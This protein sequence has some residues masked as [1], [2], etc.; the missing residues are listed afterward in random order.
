MVWV[1]REPII[2]MKKDIGS[3]IETFLRSASI[4]TQNLERLLKADEE[5]LGEERIR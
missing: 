2:S 4:D 1:D 3:T 5:E